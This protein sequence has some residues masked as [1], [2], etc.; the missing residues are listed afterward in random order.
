[1]S[2]TGSGTSI[3]RFG[4]ISCWMRLSGKIACRAS[5]GM[6]CFVPGCKGGGSG[7]GKSVSRLYQALGMSACVRSKRVCMGN[8]DSVNKAN[9]AKLAAAS[10]WVTH[11]FANFA[12]QAHSDTAP[13]LPARVL[14]KCLHCAALRWQ[15]AFPERAES[16]AAAQ[17]ANPLHCC[18]GWPPCEWP[19]CGCLCL[20]LQV[21][22]VLTCAESGVLRR[23]P[24]WSEAAGDAAV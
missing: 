23:R 2:R 7:S 19:D 8:P 15:I 6:G 14:S 24:A 22:T 1:M 5:G 21:R 3:Q 10:L 16:G 4:L 9:L 11:N 17:D 18:P 12:N 20:G 13:C